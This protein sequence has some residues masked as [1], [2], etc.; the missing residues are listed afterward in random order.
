[1]KKTT[2][3]TISRRHFLRNTAIVS[4]AAFIV[5]RYVLGGKGYTA[6]SDQITLGFIG[7]G[8]QALYLQQAFLN[9]GEAKIIAASDVYAAKLKIFTDKVNAYYAAKAGTVKYDGCAL[10]P[11]F[12]QLLDRK[13]IDAVVIATPD[14][15]HAA[16]AV[17]AAEAGKD[18]YCEKPLSLTIKEG[19]AMV[20][21]VRKHDRI[22][23]TGSMQRSWPEFRQAANLVRGGF[24]GDIKTVKV[25]VGGPSEP[26]K[27]AAEP[28]PEGLD[29]TFWLGPNSDAPFNNELAPLP[30]ANF[31]AKWRYY[32]GFGGGDLSDWG[33]HMFDIVQWALDMDNTGPVH[34]NPPDGKDYPFLTFTY[35]NGIT[36]THENFGL[37]HAIRFIGTNGQIDIQRGKIETTPATLKDHV[38]AAGE[39]KV[40]HSENHYS[41][42]LQCIRSRNK[43][44]CDIE[45]GHRSATVCNL[46]NIAYE[47]KRPL[48]WN[49]HKQKFKGDSQANALCGRKM[50]KEWNV[51]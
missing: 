9:T 2:T 30:T 17:R 16:H 44:I 28:I 31:W 13:D 49:P 35:H 25:S 46:G 32:K 21:A 36:V 7:T 50:R 10:F 24:I 11:D 42:W 19:K 4:T 39:E 12:R 33:A 15:W 45:T 38:F 6:P 48:R 20:H 27:L 41:N 3:N 23:Q 29:W 37:S 5:P 47:L 14:H 51:L 18:I 43:P 34:I 8:K 1:M 40:Y 26:Y 22:F